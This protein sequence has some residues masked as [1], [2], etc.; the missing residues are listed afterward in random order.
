MARQ[1]QRAVKTPD[2]EVP[3]AMAAV[4]SRLARVQ[5]K[6]SMPWSNSSPSPLEVPVRLACLPS[7]LS[8]VWYMKRPKAKLRYSHDGP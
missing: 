2:L 3:S 8:M 7:T 5:F 6:E 4:S 1:G